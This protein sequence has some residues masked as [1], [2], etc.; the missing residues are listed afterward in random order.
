MQCIQLA[1][2]DFCKKKR[3]HS[4]SGGRRFETKKA[5][6]SSL[7]KDQSKSS[8]Q[9]LLATISPICEYKV[10]LLQIH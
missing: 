2:V 5:G 9:R 4:V 8:Y 3:F 10:K 1:E 7:Q 6:Y